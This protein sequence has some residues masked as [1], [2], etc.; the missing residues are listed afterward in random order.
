MDGIG[1][2]GSPKI[3]PWMVDLLFSP[4]GEAE[5]AAPPATVPSVA[6]GSSARSSVAGATGQAI[7]SLQ[8]GGAI[9]PA[10]QSSSARQD[11]TVA[12]CNALVDSQQC[13]DIVQIKRRSY[14][15]SEFQLP[16]ELVGP[17]QTFDEYHKHT[18]LFNGEFLFERGTRRIESSGGAELIRTIRRTSN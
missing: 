9:P 2:V 12:E 1:A 13:H 10:G 3:E 11:M 14:L 8:A 5:A 4:P 6:V 7:A 17:T 16:T 15:V 18:E